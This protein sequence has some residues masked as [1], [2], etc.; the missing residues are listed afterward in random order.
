MLSD[1][2]LIQRMNTGLAASGYR[3]SA[4]VETIVTSPQFLNRRM[5]D[6]TRKVAN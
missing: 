4:L 6:S 5:A 2:P 1:E 3:V